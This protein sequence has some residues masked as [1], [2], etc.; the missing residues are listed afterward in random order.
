MITGI[1][2]VYLYT[3]DVGNEK[4]SCF[5]A[6]KFLDDNG[7]PHT[8]LNYSDPSQHAELLSN[9]SSWWNGALTVTGFPFVHYTEI[10]EELD[11]S[12]YPVDILRGLT[13]IRN[14]NIADLHALGS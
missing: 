1:K 13:E 12:E 2:D 4:S 10:H 9:V 8:N 3:K 14:S 6:K 5:K 11:P 7:I